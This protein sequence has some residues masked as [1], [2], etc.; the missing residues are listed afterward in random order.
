MYF[1]LKTT[2]SH[3]ATAGQTGPDGQSPG[4]TR[5]WAPQ[6]SSW[7][8][9][10]VGGWGRPPISTELMCLLFVPPYVRRA[11]EGLGVHGLRSKYTRVFLYHAGMSSAWSRAVS[12]AELGPSLH[13]RQLSECRTSWV[14]SEH[15]AGPAPGRAEAGATRGVA[16][17]GWWSRHSW[18]ST[19]IISS[20]CPA[21]LR[22]LR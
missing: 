18:I 21:P 22:V 12:G 13:L 15:R 3:L 19:E 7:S 5:P 17:S 8:P 16:S 1:L 2:E 10:V 11:S 9:H 6:L 20:D 14:W 4:A